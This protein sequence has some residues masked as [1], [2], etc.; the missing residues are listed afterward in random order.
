M[1]PPHRPGLT[2]RLLVILEDFMGLFIRT[3]FFHTLSLQISSPKLLKK[4]VCPPNPR[5]DI[6]GV[7]PV[8]KH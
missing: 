7:F 2:H 1:A 4:R 8:N 3:N 5:Q 6:V